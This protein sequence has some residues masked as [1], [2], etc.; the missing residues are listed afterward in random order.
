M[1]VEIWSIISYIILTGPVQDSQVMK[2]K[3]IKF[4]LLNIFKRN[5]YN[6]YFVGV[7]AALAYIYL[8][9]MPRTTALAVDEYF[10]NYSFKLEIFPK[11]KHFRPKI[12]RPV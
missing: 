1:L 2:L 7:K 3:K 6:K 10:Y 12:I 4:A 9:S 11:W 5:E 8:L